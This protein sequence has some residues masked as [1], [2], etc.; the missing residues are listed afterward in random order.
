MS[1]ASRVLPL[2]LDPGRVTPPLCMVVWIGLWHSTQRLHAVNKSRHEL[3]F[4]LQMSPE[5]VICCGYRRSAVQ[6]DSQIGSL[7]PP[8]S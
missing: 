3:N 8:V 2:P 1:Q 7:V 4:N 5:I 6:S